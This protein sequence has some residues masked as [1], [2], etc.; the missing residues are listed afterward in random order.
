MLDYY[1]IYLLCVCPLLVAPASWLLSRRYFLSPRPCVCVCLDFPL[2]AVPRPCTLECFHRRYFSPSFLQ[3][4]ALPVC[5]LPSL[6]FLCDIVF[7]SL[8]CLLFS[9]TLVFSCV[10]CCIVIRIS[11]VLP[12][13]TI[14]FQKFS[15]SIFVVTSCSYSMFPINI[16]HA[17][18]VSAMYVLST[19]T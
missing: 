17:S 13:I 8:F 5:C 2:S 15:L 4:A 19:R 14:Q 18:V 10:L 3:W 7:R 16:C 12:D 1:N 6:S 9:S 11:Y